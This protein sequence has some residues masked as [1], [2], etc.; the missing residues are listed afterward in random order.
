MTISKI[1][2]NRG[3]IAMRV[4]RAARDLG[5]PTVAVH[6]T[7][8]RESPHVRMADQASASALR[9]AARATSISPRSCR[10]VKS[11]APTVH[12]GYGFLSEKWPNLL[13]YA[14][15]QGSPGSGTR[16]RLTP[17]VTKS[18]RVS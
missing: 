14:A 2:A 10:S 7:V 17:W 18:E 5:I 9:R 11:P 16:R 1:C 6:S 13:S 15:S 4:I 12:P 3:E 8:D